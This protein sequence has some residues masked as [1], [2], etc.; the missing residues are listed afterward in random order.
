MVLSVALLSACASPQEAAPSPKP[1]FSTSSLEGD[2]E[3]CKIKEVS[4]DRSSAPERIQ[5]SYFPAVTNSKYFL[6]HSGTW[7]IGLVFL[8]WQDMRGNSDDEKYYKAQ[9]KKLEKWF[10][11]Q[12]Q[13]Q[14]AISFRIAQSW[15]QLPGESKAY[16]TE[17]NQQGS[18]EARAPKE[19]QLLNK[20]VAA[21]DKSFDYSD[22]DLVL[23]AIPRE[24][25]IFT[26][27]TQ[28]FE[29]NNHPNSQRATLVNTA[30]AS[31]G[32]W[33]LSGSKFMDDKDRSPSWV[34]WAHEI[35][36]MM[37]ITGHLNPMRPAGPETY[38]QN[39]MYG[40]GLFADQWTVIRTVEGWNAWMLGW[41]T[42][43]Q[44][45]CIDTKDISDEIFAVEDGRN[46]DSKKK[47]LV[48]RTGDSKVLV[49]ETR[50]FDPKRDNNTRMATAGFYNSVIMYA[51]DSTRR[52]SDGSGI[53][54]V[55]LST[56]EKWDNGKW[57]SEA[58]VFT[59]I[60]FKEGN[61]VVIDGLKIEVLS[62]QGSKNFIR[63]TKS[64]N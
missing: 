8:D 11:E 55:P 29:S 20:I 23:F 9:A 25:V 28:G 16:Y 47:L 35:G 38:F 1:T 33:I 27:G 24:R 22:L 10:A 5:F 45:N 57:P 4:P 15:S 41:I 6:P 31:I 30:E 56:D 43:D 40:V 50:L 54:Q 3:A 18:D 64:A 49:I 21:S 62:L 26:S 42:D 53:A 12:S 48:L 52:M 17:D 39:P 7:N 13:G 59:D 51:L 14:V 60:Y 63:V 46:P 58:E 36:H 2:P 44:V 19:Q 61:S 37:G 32:N 34:H